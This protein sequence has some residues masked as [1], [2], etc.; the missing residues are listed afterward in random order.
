MEMRDKADSYH[1]NN[2]AIERGAASEIDPRNGFSIRQKL[3]GLFE[4]L[5]GYGLSILGIGSVSRFGQA[6]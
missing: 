5:T 2:Y 4:P 6:G 3:V 1:Q